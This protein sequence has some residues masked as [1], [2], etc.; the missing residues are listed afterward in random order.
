MLWGPKSNKLITTGRS[1]EKNNKTMYRLF[2]RAGKIDIHYSAEDLD[3][4]RNVQYRKLSH[5][6]LETLDEVTLL[7]SNVNITDL[8]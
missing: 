1:I 3:D 2:T 7:I 5:K 6:D 4:K 8:S